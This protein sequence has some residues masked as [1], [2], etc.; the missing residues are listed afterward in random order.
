M[1]E[2]EHERI[3]G[4]LM[5]LAVYLPMV[6]PLV[7]V[8]AFFLQLQSFSEAALPWQTMADWPW[9]RTIDDG[10]FFAIAIS[11][12]R[13]VNESWTPPFLRRY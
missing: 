3:S 1:D 8:T 13:L 10:L 4:C 7:P 12:Y 5:V 2:R 11:F 9:W 6:L